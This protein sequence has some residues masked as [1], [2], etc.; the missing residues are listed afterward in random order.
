MLD[1]LPQ[2]KRDA[3]QHWNATPCGSGE[4]L[5]SLEYG[6]KEYFDEVRRSRYSVTDTWMLETIDFSIANGKKLLEVGHGL[7][8]DLLTFAEHGA[9]V[10][11][12]DLTQEHHRMARRN[13][14]LHG[15]PVTLELSDAADL[16]FASNS[17]DVVYSHG[18]LHH[19]PDT[20]RCIS[21]IYRVLK[22]GGTMILTLYYTYSAFHIFSKILAHGVVR[23]DLFR[24]GYRGLMATLEYGADGTKT[25]PL[26]KT[27]SKRELRCMLQDFTTV[28]FRIA[29]FKRDH[30]PVLGWL[31]PPFLET[32]LSRV[33]GW[34]VVAVAVK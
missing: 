3:Q 31:I 14:E 18:V 11:G 32:P 6:S 12:V 27:Y 28:R 9:E 1:E 19:T 8:S 22:P 33:T 13:F 24:L 2:A 34:Y 20:V 26:V 30:I 21:E 23:G 7:G 10:Y 5:E 25:K 15:R 29:H 16:P 17:F 4:Y